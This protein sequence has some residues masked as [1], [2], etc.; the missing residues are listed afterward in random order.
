MSFEDRP[1][2][3]SSCVNLKHSTVG[4]WSLAYTLLARVFTW[5]L[6]SLRRLFE[7]VLLR[8]TLS[9]RWRQPS[10]T[11]GAKYDKTATSTRISRSG[12]FFRL[13]SIHC[14]L[15]TLLWLWI[16]LIVLALHPHL[17]HASSMNVKGTSFYLD[18][19]KNRLLLATMNSMRS[20]SAGVKSVGL[21]A[22]L[23]L[24]LYLIGLSFSCPT[25]KGP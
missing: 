9:G 18:V 20:R 17:V 3:A 11:L 10:G 19:K 14:V 12:R 16:F 6:I 2:W 23:G 21:I 7:Q 4:G 8:A 13:K 25:D 1:Y 24:M 15:A 5:S 22:V